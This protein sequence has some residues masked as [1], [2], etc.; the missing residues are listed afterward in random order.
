MGVYLGDGVEVGPLEESL[1]GANL[2]L[3]T[4]SFTSFGTSKLTFLFLHKI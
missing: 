3:T 1:D 4:V 2:F